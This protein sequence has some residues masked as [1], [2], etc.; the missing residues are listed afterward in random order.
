M[1][2]CMRYLARLVLLRESQSGYDII[3]VYILEKSSFR[4]YLFKKN[5][6]KLTRE[7]NHS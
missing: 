6:G 4:Y 5:S 3:S 1:I 2:A 7:K